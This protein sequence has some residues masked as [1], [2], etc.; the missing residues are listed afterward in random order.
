MKDKFTLTIDREADEKGTRVGISIDADMTN[1]RGSKLSGSVCV[2]PQCDSYQKL[3]KEI[4]AAKEAL[5]ILLKESGKLF[6]E[7]H[8]KE[9]APDV[10]ESM[11]AKEIWD[12]LST[13][14]DPEVLLMK[15]NSM[16]H[17]TRIEVADYV[18]THCNV[19][20]SPASIFSM[21]YNIEEGLLE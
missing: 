5:D 17:Q 4:A 2:I 1:G 19:F 14:K 11:S 9:E 12:L 13:I 21:R 7:E 18:L 15:F 6:D 16:S 20:S 8:K 3:K 10:D